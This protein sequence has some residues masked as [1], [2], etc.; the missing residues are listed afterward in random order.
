MT[1]IALETVK[2]RPRALERKVEWPKK[3]FEPRLKLPTKIVGDWH[4]EQK[5]AGADPEK[6]RDEF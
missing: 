4:L 3:R 1:P 6:K 2:S 5:F